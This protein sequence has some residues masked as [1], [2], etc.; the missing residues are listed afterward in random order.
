MQI[1]KNKIRL[2][3]YMG[4]VS[5]IVILTVLLSFNFA[6][7]LQLEYNRKIKQ[8]SSGIIQEK[9]RFL[10]NAVDR[11][12]QMIEMERNQ[13]NQEAEA[14]RR[15]PDQIDTRTI[16][17]IK[18][19]IHRLRL[20]DDGYVWV[21]RI[22]NHNGGD[23]YAVR[24]IHPNLPETE[25][26]WLS[27][28]TTDIKGNKPYQAELDGMNK[29]G[30]LYFDYYFKKMNSDIIAHKMSYAKLYKP[31]DWVVATGVYLDDVD[32]LIRKET[33]LMHATHKSQQQFSF[34]VAIIAIVISSLVLIIFERLISR[35]IRSYEFKIR[36]YTDSLIQEKEKTEQA[37]NE[38]KKLSGL[39]PICANCK[40]IRDDQGYW[41]LL[42]SYI[43]KHSDALF[44][45]GICPECLASLYPDQYQ[46][47]KK[48]GKI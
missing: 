22:V 38:V 16:E 14:G 40:K 18:D 34:Y 27:T 39:L 2:Y 28:N 3:F 42:E 5:S 25:G 43:E 4:S 13:A 26:M 10:K 35:L 46:K 45:H 7:A 17:R 29:N 23:K 9:K 37:L 1:A 6:E 21:N 30:E 47:M 15:S 24:E 12:I 20:I 33:E 41:N 8:L 31:Y 32:E 44:S 11:T 19:Q 48:A 36:K